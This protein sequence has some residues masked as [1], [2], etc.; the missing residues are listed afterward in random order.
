MHA[1]ATSPFHHLAIVLVAVLLLSA[2]TGCQSLR[3]ISSLR[4][5]DF[6]LDR[7]SG[8]QL[9]GIDIERVRSYNDLTGSDLLRVGR[10]VSQN[11]MPFQFTV[12]VSANNPEENQRQAR[13]VAF[14]WTL[15]LD[16]RETIAGTFNETV[17]LPA[18]EVVDVPLRMELD[19]LNFF[20]RSARDLVEL[21]L[22]VAGAEG[23]SSR[24]QLRARP[25]IDTPI[26]P[27]RYPND[28]T[29]VSR[30]VGTP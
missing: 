5:V 22:A 9:A 17:R 12:H 21:A 13:M 4:Q 23:A 14:D 11:E 16:E 15:L 27:I 28:I 24:I 30:D 29:I 2:L 20:E 19:L 8:A 26:G 25:S 3:E 10:A 18:G 7:V 1:T 6:A